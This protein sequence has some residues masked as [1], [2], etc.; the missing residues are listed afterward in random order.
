MRLFPI[1]GTALGGLPVIVSGIVFWGMVL[2]G[3][4]AIALISREQEN[5]FY[6]TA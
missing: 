4:V 2:V 3:L 5:S 6:A 1:Q